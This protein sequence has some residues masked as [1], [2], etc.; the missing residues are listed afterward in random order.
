MLLR[1][2]SH[3]TAKESNTKLKLAQRHTPS[4]WQSQ[5]SNLNP[6]DSKAIKIYTQ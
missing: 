6:S 5:C 1:P 3:L 4:K 2:L